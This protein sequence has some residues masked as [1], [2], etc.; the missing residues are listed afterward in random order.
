MDADAATAR[1]LWLPFEIL[2]DVGGGS[3]AADR[4]VIATGT[5]DGIG[6]DQ[7]MLCGCAT[8]LS[9]IRND[10]HGWLIDGVLSDDVEGCQYQAAW[11]TAYSVVS[12][13]TGC[14]GMKI[15]PMRM[16][17]GGRPS[18]ARLSAQP[19]QRHHWRLWRARKDSGPGMIRPGGWSL[20]ST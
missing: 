16:P 19:K 2:L 10:Y 8:A 17:S 1:A 12:S 18:A 13:S 15:R 9:R 5:S 6:I 3:T 11:R 20:M 4:N 14:D 7:S